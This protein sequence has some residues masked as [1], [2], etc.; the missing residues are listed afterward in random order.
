MSEHGTKTRTGKLLSYYLR[1][2]SE[3]ITEYVKDP[4]TGEDRLATKAEALARKIWQDALGHKETT[5]RDSKLIE[6][7]RKS[8]V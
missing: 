7:I 8:V 2:I 3:E 1:Q 4:I 5:V 6:V